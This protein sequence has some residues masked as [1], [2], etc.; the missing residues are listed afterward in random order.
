MARGDADMTLQ[1][2]SELIHAAGVEV[3][4]PVPT[5]RAVRVG[6]Q[7]GHRRWQRAR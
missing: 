2:L 5:E 1:P 7:R 6:V 4:G 3:V